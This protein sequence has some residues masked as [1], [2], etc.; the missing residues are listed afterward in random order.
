VGQSFKAIEK[1]ERYRE[2]A[3]FIHIYLP[4]T[5]SEFQTKPERSGIVAVV[6]STANTDG[7]EMLYSARVLDHF[8]NTLLDDFTED[9]RA[10]SWLT[11][12]K[13][14]SVACRVFFH[15]SPYF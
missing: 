10:I 13:A 1:T 9:R 11:Q 8:L 15:L 3:T 7:K 2:V 14:N 4:C 12:L 6:H 5:G